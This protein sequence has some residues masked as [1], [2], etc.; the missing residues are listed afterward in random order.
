VLEFTKPKLTVLETTA[1][2][3]LY[4]GIDFD[5]VYDELLPLLI[6]L[7]VDRFHISEMDAQTLAHEVFLSYFLKA[8]E[9]RDVRAWLVGAICNASRQFLKKKAR[10]VELPADITEKPDPRREHVALPDQI[11]ARQAFVCDTARCQLAL[12]LRFLE[13]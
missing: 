1:P 9:V 6:S 2:Q 8:D 13:G 3:C 5:A 10:D 4:N 12:R 7:A 11:A